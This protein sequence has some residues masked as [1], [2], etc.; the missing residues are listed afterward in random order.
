MKITIRKSV[1]ETNSS[2]MH[3]F[4]WETTFDKSELF[5]PDK[6]DFYMENFGWSSPFSKIEETEEKACYLYTTAVL[7]DKVEE[8]EDAIRAIAKDL[9]FEYSFK[10]GEP[11]DDGYIDHQSYDDAKTLLH[12]VLVN[13]IN[14]INF[15]FRSDT[16]CIIVGDCSD[17]EARYERG[18]IKVGG[19]NYEI[20]D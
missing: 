15:L 1:F 6:V 20:N 14:L 10:R 4:S 17:I 8:F 2:S 9:G 12:L 18:R 5:I 13:D 16:D 3:S 11:Y 7:S 19:Y